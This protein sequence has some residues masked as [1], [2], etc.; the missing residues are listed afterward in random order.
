MTAPKLVIAAPVYNEG[1]LARTFVEEVDRVCTKVREK[2]PEGSI[3]ILI[4]NDGSTDNTLDHLRQASLRHAHRLRV[5]SLI[6]NF[7]YPMAVKC[8]LDHAE[9]DG[10]ILMDADFQDAPELIPSLLKRHE[11]TLA[12]IVCV[13]RM[14]RLDSFPRRWLLTVFNKLYKALTGETHAFGTFGFY[15]RRAV[16]ALRSSKEYRRYHPALVRR[17]GLPVSFI[18]AVR[19][20][21]REGKSQIG[22]GTAF[23]LALDAFL[24]VCWDRPFTRIF[25][26]D[27]Q[28]P[29]YLINRVDTLQRGTPLRPVEAE[30]T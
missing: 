17:T 4:A 28:R 11:E 19:S 12:D 21:R 15:T 29:H 20:K 7:G 16:L 24:S 10:L 8:L 23:R 5:I 14:A 1:P 26:Q 25:E 6:R 22:L 3:E 9:G 13:E 2:D 27:R 30:R 18:P